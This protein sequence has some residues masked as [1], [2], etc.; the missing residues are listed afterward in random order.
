MK[1]FNKKEKKKY[2]VVAGD[3]R[4]VNGDEF[5]IFSLQ[6]HSG[7]QPSDPSKS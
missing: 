5:N 7:H 3:E 6:S 1:I 4:I 2:H